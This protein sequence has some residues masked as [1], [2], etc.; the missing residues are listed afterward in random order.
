MQNEID[1]QLPDLDNQPF[2]VRILNKE[3]TLEYLQ[4]AIKDHYESM[5]KTQKKCLELYTLENG[6]S[7]TY[8]DL[9]E[10]HKTNHNI[11]LMK[12]YFDKALLEY[13]EMVDKCFPN[14]LPMMIVFSNKN[15]YTKGGQMYHLI[16]GEPMHH[17]IP[18]E[19][20]ILGA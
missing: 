17:L 4:N 10:Y 16:P 5:T 15:H 9:P 8:S 20:T 3:G 7:P 18:D 19:P 6:R 14:V 1:N 12:E 11:K 13:A 2:F